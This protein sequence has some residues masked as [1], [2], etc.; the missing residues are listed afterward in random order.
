MRGLGLCIGCRHAYAQ[1]ADVNPL[2]PAVHLVNGTGLCGVCALAAV[3]QLLAAP[4]VTALETAPGRAPL[5]PDPPA[6]P[7]APGKPPAP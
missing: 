7:P 3:G 6:P 2:V 1:G 5:P 4:V